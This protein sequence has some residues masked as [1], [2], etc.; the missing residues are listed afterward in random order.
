MDASF[1]AP[2]RDT[3]LSFGSSAAEHCAEIRTHLKRAATPISPNDL[4][5]AAKRRRL[6]DGLC[7][8]VDATS[9]AWCMAEFDPDKPPS[10]IGFEHG[11]WDEARFARCVEAMN[12]PDM[13]A[14]TRQASVELKEKGTQLTRTLRRAWW[15]WR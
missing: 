6:M 12:H 14:V 1:E 4:I 5:F 9:W 7:E 2:A 15:M 8:L 13:E 10:F 3:S 11:V